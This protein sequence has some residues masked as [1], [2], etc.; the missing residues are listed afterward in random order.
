MKIKTMF[1]DGCYKII[2]FLQISLQITYNF[3]KKLKVSFRTY[4]SF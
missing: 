3:N 1:L 4:T 2:N